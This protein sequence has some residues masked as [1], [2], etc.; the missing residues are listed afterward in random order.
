VATLAIRKTTWNGLSARNKELVKAV[1]NLLDLGVPAEWRTAA[2]VRWFLFDDIRFTLR[3]LAYFGALATHLGDIPA[4]YQIPA[5]RAELR[6][7]AK[8]FLDPFVVWPVT[9]PEGTVNVWQVVLDAQGTPAAMQMADHPPAT[10][11]PVT[12]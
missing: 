6:A 10:W 7:D 1:G 4:G 5:T 8:A 9:I 12:P 11:I 3:E 2:D